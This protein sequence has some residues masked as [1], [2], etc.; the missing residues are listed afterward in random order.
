METAYK[1]EGGKV[2][3]SGIGEGEH[4]NSPLGTSTSSNTLLPN[5]STFYTPLEYHWL[6]EG[7]TPPPIYKAEEFLW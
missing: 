3:A 5:L 4:R 6:R 7:E 2:T 1:H